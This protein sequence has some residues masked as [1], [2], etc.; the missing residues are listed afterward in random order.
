LNWKLR[1][2]ILDLLILWQ[3]LAKICVKAHD[4]L[5]N[6]VCFT[7]ADTWVDDSHEK[8]P[9]G[10][11]SSFPMNQLFPRRSFHHSVQTWVWMMFS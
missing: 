9:G 10:Q 3:Y 2:L 11:Y 8:M 1:I 6:S 5:S 4:W 7:Q